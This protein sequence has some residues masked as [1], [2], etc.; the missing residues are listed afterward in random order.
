MSPTSLT[1]AQIQL[2][3]MSIAVSAQLPSGEPVLLRPL[4]TTDGE[5][6]GAYF[7]ALSPATRGHF[8]PHPLDR[9][10][11]AALCTAIDCGRELRWVAVKEGAD[12]ELIAYFILMWS[13]TVYETARYADRGIALSSDLDCT[14]APSVADRYQN[15][16]LGGQMLVP[17]LAIA[18]RLGR[19]HMVLLG[20]TH[21]DNA[22]AIAFYRRH[23]FQKVGTF[24][25]PP[26]V[27]NA[28]MWLA[29]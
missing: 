4:L 25:D 1:L 18:R 29:I 6:L 19:R 13:V 27:L 9:S 3:P 15:V 26:G 10:T 17:L 28:D 22:R 24:E 20:G 14:F 8:G 16:G 5:R 11:A 21:A 7:E 23:G 12:T 2:D